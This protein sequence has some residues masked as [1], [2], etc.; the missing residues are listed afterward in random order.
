MIRKLVL[1]PRPLCGREDQGQN[2]DVVL[3]SE[4][5]GDGGN[6]LGGL[7]THSA[8]TIEAEEF[9]AAGGFGDAIG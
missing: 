4:G 7:S 1:Y 5:F 2:G 8:G 9:V 6:L 3:L